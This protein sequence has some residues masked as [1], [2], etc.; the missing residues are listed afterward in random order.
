MRFLRPRNM[1]ELRLGIVFITVA[2]VAG[3]LL[4]QKQRIMTSTQAW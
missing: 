3:L 2:V 1:S 4:F